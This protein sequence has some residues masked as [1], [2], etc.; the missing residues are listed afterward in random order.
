MQTRAIIKAALNAIGDG[1]DAKVDIMVPFVGKVEEFR[2][3]AALIRSV[4]ETVF[5]ERKARCDFIVG[6]KIE[7]LCA[8][9][10]Y[11]KI[12]EKADLF[13]FG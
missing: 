1:V 12:A 2:I 13:S 8:A 3:Q 4:A 10:T 6:N 5:K 9:L 11:H 7:L